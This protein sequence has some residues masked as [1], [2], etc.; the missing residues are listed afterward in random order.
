MEVADGSYLL[1]WYGETVGPLRSRSVYHVV[2]VHRHGA[3]Q[4]GVHSLVHPLTDGL[5]KALALIQAL[6]GKG[7]VGRWVQ[8]RVSN[9]LYLGIQLGAQGWQARY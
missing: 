6:R 7:Y 2:R 4:A 9:G 8:P 1:A 3:V 5:A